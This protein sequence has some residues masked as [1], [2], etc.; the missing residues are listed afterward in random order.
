M[1]RTIRTGFA[2]LF[3]F[4]IFIMYFT[5]CGNLSDQKQIQ[6]YNPIK[7]YAAKKDATFHYD[8][9]KVIEGDGYKTH[10][11]RMVSGQWL[12]TNE[13][14]DPEWWHWVHIVVP[15][16]LSSSTALLF[17]G[18]GDRDRHEPADADGLII[19]AAK[20]AG[21]VT[22]HLHNV[23][24]QP[25]E[26]VGDDFG[27]REE[28]ELIAYGWRKFME[29]G[30]GKESVEW[31]AR[32][33][34]TRAAV[35]AMDAAQEYSKMK[36]E[37]TIDGFVVAGGSKR[38]WTTWAAAIADE[39]VVAIAPIV[40]DVL[41][42][43]PSFQHHWRAYGEWSPAV[44]DYVSEGVMDWFGSMEF[45]KL[46]DLVEPYS[47]RDMLT[48]PKMM[49]NAAGDEFF[50]NDSWQF[51]WDDLVGEKNIRYVPNTGH[52]LDESDAGET[53]VAYFNSIVKNAPRPKFEWKVENGE[54]LIKTDP[55]FVLQEVRLW[56][57]TNDTARD[58]RIYVTE[59]AWTSELVPISDN[60]EYKLSVPTPEKGWTAFMGELTFEG[61]GGTPF[62][63]TTGVL[64]TPETLP[65]PAF[66]S[67]NPQGTR[68]AAK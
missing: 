63:M 34:M 24:N 6:K 15:E 46:L 23:P 42:T 43:I 52:G 62:K 1:S 2:H 59:K 8:L 41:N 29:K 47:Y 38:G 3:V 35:R 45:E 56:S 53:L 39:R 10:I 28:D 11:L 19:A 40:I 65:F 4:F 18:G 16:N 54:I 25:V 49:I 66:E 7:E 9:H 44:E 61:P 55:A 51:Y 26:F 14:K 27:P 67:S 13:V 32:L 37:H 20:T 58:F 17:I 12:T 64:V 60:G 36:L 5:G 31:L 57:A 48:L 50:L 68:I 21:A 33:P 22:M 30:A